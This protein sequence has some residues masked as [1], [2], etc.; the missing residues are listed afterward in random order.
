MAATIGICEQR[1][2]HF[3]TLDDTGGQMRPFVRTNHHRHMRQ[4]PR[5]N[6]VAIAID[7]MDDARTR[8]MGIRARKT[9]LQS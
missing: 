9:L 6:A 7:A 8:Q 4:G 5:P 2:E 1:V 3:R